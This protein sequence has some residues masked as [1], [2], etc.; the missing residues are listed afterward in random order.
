MD[1]IT[2]I[3]ERIMAEANAAC[4]EISEKSAQR[5]EAI[6]S[7]YGTKAEDAY[8]EL[9]SKGRTEIDIA[10]QRYVRNA[11]INSRKDILA[12]KQDM[13]DSVFAA[14]KEKIC[15]MPAKEYTAWLVSLVTEA[16]CSGDEELILDA[17]DSAKGAEIVEKANAALAAKGGKAQLR[18]SDTVRDIT[19]GIILRKG[20]IETNCTL[21]AILEQARKDLA[22]AVAE[23]LF[24]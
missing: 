11:Q 10:A 4:A 20:N 18:L 24:G 2:K 9:V 14:A 3:T 17:R 12:L 15:S 6:R 23:Q 16:A 1:G 22:S 13:I 21:D 5:C 7:E 8:A 19:G